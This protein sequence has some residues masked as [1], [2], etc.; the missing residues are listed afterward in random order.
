MQPEDLNLEKV[1]SRKLKQDQTF[2]LQDIPRVRDHGDGVD[3]QK[4]VDELKK[5]LELK[6]QL[7]RNQMEDLRQRMDAPYMVPQT[8]DFTQAIVEE[9]AKLNDINQHIDKCQL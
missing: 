5:D 9:Q 2:T 6:Q 8:Q 7:R 4:E 3:L 1:K